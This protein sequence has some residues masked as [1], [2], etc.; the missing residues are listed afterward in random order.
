MKAL[1]SF[2]TLAAIHATTRRPLQKDPNPKICCFWYNVETRVVRRL[3][4][5]WIDMKLR[6]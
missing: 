6:L 2:E 3:C 1:R 4:L 5:R